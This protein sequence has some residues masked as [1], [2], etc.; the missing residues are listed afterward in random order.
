MSALGRDFKYGPDVVDRQA[1]GLSDGLGGREAADAQPVQHEALARI[2]IELVG[3]LLRH[4]V[5]TGAG[6]EHERERS[7]RSRAS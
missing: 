3:H 5:P 7:S 1:N 6:S 2:G 4:G